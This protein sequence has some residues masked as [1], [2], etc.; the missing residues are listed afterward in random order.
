[1]D[2]LDTLQQ[3]LT[4][5]PGIGP[6]QARRFAFFFLQINQD[7]V[8]QLIDTISQLRSN[9]YHCSTC[10]RLFFKSITHFDIHTCPTCFDDSRDNSKILLVAKQADF[11]NIE[12][13]G[14][15]DGRYFIL[16]RTVKLSDKNPVESLPVALLLQQLSRFDLDELVIGLPINPEG[17]YTAETIIDATQDVTKSGQVKIS[18]LA[19][20][21]SVGSELEYSDPLTIEEALKN[22]N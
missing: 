17:E 6:R 2:K 7:Y 13:S 10:N 16:G 11:E 12:R 19:R 14:S 9:K 5:L 18:H 22:R 8:D 21:L 1:M 4:K 3:L 20:G 15:W